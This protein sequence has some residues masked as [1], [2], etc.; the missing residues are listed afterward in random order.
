VDAG[1]AAI[2]GHRVVA[3]GLA[4]AGE[5]LRGQLVG[6]VPADLLEAGGGAAH[7]PPQTVR[8]VLEVPKSHDLGADV[9]LGE[10]IEHVS[11]DPGDASALRLHLDAT[12]GFTEAAGRV[13]R[14]AHGPRVS[15]QEAP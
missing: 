5:A 8:I 6:L 9:S 3:P 10:G 15:G 14:S 11:P 7:G 4:H 13:G 2:E 12:G 1:I